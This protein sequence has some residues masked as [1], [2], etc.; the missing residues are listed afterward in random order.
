[1]SSQ[2]LS[3]TTAAI[4]SPSDPITPLSPLPRSR[5]IPPPQTEP[6][7]QRRRRAEDARGNDNRQAFLTQAAAFPSW[8]AAEATVT[9]KIELKVV[10][11]RRQSPR[12]IIIRKGELLQPLQIGELVGNTTRQLVIIQNQSV[13]VGAAGEILRYLP[14]QTVARQVE[15][16]E[17]G[18]PGAD[19][20]RD[21]AGEGVAGEIEGLD[22]VAEL[23]GGGE[24]SG[25]GEIPELEADEAVLTVIPARDAD[26]LADEADGGVGEVP[27]VELAI[28]VGQRGLHLA[29]ALDVIL[30]G[31]GGEEEQQQQ[32]EE[33]ET[34]VH[35]WVGGG[36]GGG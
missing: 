17:I 34:V 9:A 28:G 1:M 13:E 16:G 3:P 33:E 25:E 30:G 7:Q 15:S 26:E 20:G 19:F 36:G 35:G 31:G 32:G 8:T 22:A 27:R 24:V 4:I 5:E 23:Q 6:Q 10:T 11:K 21:R 12:Q 29:E 2:S 18:Q 14:G